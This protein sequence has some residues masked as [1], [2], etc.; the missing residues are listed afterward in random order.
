MQNRFGGKLKEV[1]IF[2]NQSAAGAKKKLKP[3]YEFTS[4]CF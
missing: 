1:Y 4:V 3:A 2:I